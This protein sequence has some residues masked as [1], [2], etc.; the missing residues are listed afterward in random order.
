MEDFNKNQNEYQS[1]DTN[2]TANS[3]AE[4]IT[5]ENSAPQTAENP[6]AGMPQQNDFYS[7]SSYV[8]PVYVTKK[9]G[10]NPL[11]VIL[12]I[13]AVVIAAVVVFII[14]MLNKP[15]SY[16][17]AEKNFF[18]SLFS[19]AGQTEELVSD[20]LGSEKLSVDFS[21]P[22]GEL[23]GIDLSQYKLEIDTANGDDAVYALINAMLGEE[24]NLSAEMWFDS[25]QG[26]SY[27]FFP[28]ISDIYAVIDS[29]KTVEEP[30][31]YSRYSESLNK[32]I[33]MTSEVYFE[34]VGDP[35]TEKNAQF[36][37]NGT[38]YTADKAVVHLDIS[39]LATVCKAFLENLSENADTADMLC[40]MGG[41]DTLEEMR[42]EIKE[43]TDR[44]QESIDGTGDANG[45]FDMSVYMKN[46]TVVGREIIISD[47][48]LNEKIYIDLYHI[49]DEAVKNGYFRFMYDTDDEYALHQLTFAVTDNTTGNIHS[50]N[51][52]LE[53]DDGEFDNS[54]TAIKASY[55]DLSCTEDSFGGVINLSISGGERSDL[56]KLSGMSEISAVVNLL[57]DG[58]KKIVSVTVPNIC[59]VN[60][61]LEPSELTFKAVPSP[62][63]GKTAVIS[64]DTDDNY[65]A[66]GQLM[67]DFSDYFFPD[68]G[69]NYGG[70]DDP[71]DDPYNIPEV[72]GANEPEVSESEE[73]EPEVTTFD[74]QERP[75]LESAFAS[76][77]IGDWRP[78]KMRVFGEDIDLTEEEYSSSR[79]IIYTFSE[80][81]VLFVANNSDIIDDQY[82]IYYFDSVDDRRILLIDNS[83]YMYYDEISD[84]IKS[85]DDEDTIVVW[86]ERY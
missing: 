51:I 15:A 19:A 67:E 26:K 69:S 60:F 82:F 78:F 72:V 76:A 32:V 84:T 56:T 79:K 41:F 16:R 8:S 4:N 65:E 38:T 62:A 58:E 25:A 6:F 48:E 40:Q 10:I 70:Y 46:N 73:N 53:I 29:S 17:E 9:R 52:S 28:E 39:Q 42:E 14:L 7:E 74:V 64:G 30:K 55:N 59:T 77:V 1:T 12:P 81:G 83:G 27:I 3:A 44:M 57:K 71:Y 68:Y 63:P 13:A 31:D 36:T 50:G 5:V 34:V 45:A 85:A 20:N 37:V 2:Q 49:S 61:T 18:G 21:T 43:L 54:I 47:Y 66:F 35:V 75:V 11:A 80:D 33:E 86:L 23:S 24:M 22:L